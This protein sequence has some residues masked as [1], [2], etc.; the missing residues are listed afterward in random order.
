MLGSTAPVSIPGLLVTAN[1][2]LLSAI[3]YIQMVCPGMA[4]YYAL[5]STMLNPHTGGCVSSTVNQHFLQF[6]TTELGHFY[7]LPVM[8]SYGSGDSKVFL[9]DIEVYQSTTTLGSTG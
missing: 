2:E 7:D 4:A 6:G 5:Y 3:C 8:S 9:L 1:A